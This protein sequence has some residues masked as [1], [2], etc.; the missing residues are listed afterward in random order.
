MATAPAV[1]GAMGQA[2]MYLLLPM[3]LL[4]CMLAGATRLRCAAA[5]AEL[6]CPRC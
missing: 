3:L 5:V 1:A 4:L 2:Q 6:A